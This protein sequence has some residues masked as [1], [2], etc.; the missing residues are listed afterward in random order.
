LKLGPLHPV[1]VENARVKLFRTRENGG[2]DPVSGYTEQQIRAFLE[3]VARGE[4]PEPRYF[5][6]VLAEARHYAAACL[7]R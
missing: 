6:N 1:H 7:R 5:D 3:K 4:N 2:I